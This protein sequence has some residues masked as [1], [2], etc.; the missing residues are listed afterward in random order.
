VVDSLAATNFTLLR[1]ARG[2]RT[3]PILPVISQPPFLSGPELHAAEQVF[4][5]EIGETE[6]G[7]GDL[8]PEFFFSPRKPIQLGP[9]ASLV[10]GLG[11]AFQFPTATDDELGTGKWS[12]GPGFVVFL[13][14]RAL[15]VTT[16]FLILNLWSFAGDEDRA[17]V[18]AMTL[19]PFLN[20]NLPKGW[21]LTA[22]PLIT[23]NWEAG[24]D[25]RWTVPIGGGI[26]RIFKIGHQAINANIAAYYNVVTPDDTGANWQ[27]RAEWTFLFPEH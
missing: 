10:W 3:R 7:L 20:Y 12:A 2:D 26:G 19:Q 27:L 9:E 1:P 24:E 5:P 11:P 15:H 4:G 23:A 21:Y 25:N 13:S 17:D 14:D 8:T 16:G 22:S 6:F 18:N